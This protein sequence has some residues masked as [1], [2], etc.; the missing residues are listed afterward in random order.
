MMVTSEQC[1]D[2]LWYEFG[3]RYCLSLVEGIMSVVYAIVCL[4]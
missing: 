4:W 2:K 3:I 1:I